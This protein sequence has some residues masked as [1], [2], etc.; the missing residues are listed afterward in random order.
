MATEDVRPGVAIPPGEHLAEELE[1]RKMTQTELARRMGRPQQAVNEIIR[2]VKAITAETA[3]QLEQALGIRAETWVRL[4]GNYRL[5]LAR[6]A[7]QRPEK[8]PRRRHGGSPAAI[9]RR[10]VRARVPRAGSARKNA[11]PR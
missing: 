4:E 2:G 9:P 3:L 8:S 1:A 6:G 5:T 10:A 7:A 11:G